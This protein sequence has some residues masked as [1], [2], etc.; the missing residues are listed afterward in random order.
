MRCAVLL[1]AFL[2]PA[3]AA[4][5]V[6]VVNP[7]VAGAI[8]TIGRAAEMVQPGDVVRIYAGTYRESVAVKQSGTKEKP[9]RFEAA[10]GAT[11]VITG[12]DR[13]TAWNREPGEGN[14]FSAA[15]PY[16][17]SRTH[18][19]DEYHR[20]IGRAEQ[21]FVNGYPLR[22]VESK[23]KIAR[24][25]FWVDAEAKR[26]WAQSM[27]DLDFTGKSAV[28]EASVRP[29][30]W[31]GDGEFVH[32]RGLQFRYA[33]NL[34]QRGAAIFAGR[35]AV[36]EDCV[37]ERTNS[38]GAQFRAEDI[39]VR[40]S[41]FAEN[42]Q[43]GFSAN[44]AHR[45]L[46][47]GITVRGNNV[48]GFKRG[49]EAGGNKLVYSRGVVIEQIVFSGNRDSGIWFDIG[50]EDS[51]VR[52][53]LIENNEDGGIFYEISYGLHAH[54]NVIVG[55][56][57]ADTAGAWGS[58]AGINLSSSPNCVIERNLLIGNREGFAFREQLR[59]TGRIDKPE[60][61]VWNHDQAIRNNVLAYNVSSQLAGW[62]DVKDQ[63]HW[64]RTMQQAEG[65]AAALSLE[66]LKLIVSGNVYARHPAE[67]LVQWGTTWGRH[68]YYDTLEAFS[69]EL[70]LEQ[71]GKEVDL[72]FADPTVKDYR[73]PAG[74]AVLRNCMPR[75]AIPGV[76]LGEISSRQ[77]KR[78]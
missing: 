46:M 9:I 25:T 39:V 66:S 37:F 70:K 51:T 4:A 35:G 41:V 24:G 58:Q 72:P 49:W 21:V 61:A 19:N 2:T 76:R 10:P 43:L 78:L 53:N 13:I 50:N 7:A 77:V 48:K 1:I 20:L 31:R 17:A 47:S 11:V 54:D 5:R 3:P 55:N 12:A 26:L 33:A 60:E 71:N 67:R 45:M 14:I 56:G 22:Q 75:G 28:V 6:L 16:P 18:P 44:R 68:Q 36:V 27:E 69:A 42:G 63:R 38:I 15:W 59:R 40:R 73:L 32:V 8:H 65:A 64:P 34:A 30:L 57:L 29:L 62:F 74:N 23:D 52:N